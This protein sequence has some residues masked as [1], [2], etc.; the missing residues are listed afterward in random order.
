MTIKLLE[1]SLQ[2]HKYEV[3]CPEEEIAV[4]DHCVDYLNAKIVELEGQQRGRPQPW[5][6]TLVAAALNLCK[7]L[8]MLKKQHQQSGMEE[9]AIQ[10][11]INKVEQVLTAN[12]TTA[13]EN[14]E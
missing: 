6:Y 12:Q 3:K 10:S 11:L 5:D 8:L 14:F 9:K 4:L 1:I 2:N 13:A 7:E